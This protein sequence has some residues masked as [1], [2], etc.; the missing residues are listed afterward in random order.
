MQYQTIPYHSG[1]IVVL[2]DLHYDSYRRFA[3]SPIDQWALQDIV[4]YADA[5]ILAGD[6][7]NGPADRWTQ[8]F[9]YLSE[10]I[11]PERIYA[12]PGN[13]NYYS[14]HLTDDPKLERV[15]KDVDA[16]FA[17]KTALLHGDT[18]ILCCTL[19]TDFNLSDEPSVAMHTADLLMADYHMIGAPLDPS[20]PADRIP[21]MRRERRLEPR[22]ILRVH[23]DHRAWL[24]DNLANPHP[25]G[26]NGRTV[27]ITHHG[28]HLAVA[29]EIDT[30]SAAFHSDM[31]D[32]IIQYR[33]DAWFFAHSHRRLRAK[34][35]GTDIRNVSV[36]YAGELIDES[37]SYLREAVLWKSYS[38]TVKSG[39]G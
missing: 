39:G 14:G 19:W 5:L 11:R 34:I 2:G 21:I 15:A 35:Y 12:L 17:Q 7:T 25:S 36:G 10:F 8:V 37:V 26:S 20:T 6:L 4:W 33:P 38:A 28:P 13:H 27:I 22:E 29:G 18:R 31:S 3:L 1:E 16:H 30:L 23:Q 9:Q 32:L 24:A